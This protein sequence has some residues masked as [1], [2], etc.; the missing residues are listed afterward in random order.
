M[1]GG[2]HAILA[3]I[4]NGVPN[5]PTANGVPKKLSANNFSPDFFA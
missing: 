1:G 3:A 2:P 4:A 5:T